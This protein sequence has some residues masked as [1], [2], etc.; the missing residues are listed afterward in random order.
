[1]AL[2]KQFG[3]SKLTYQFKKRGNIFKLLLDAN[4]ASCYCLAYISPSSIIKQ[5][6]SGA[7][8]CKFMQRIAIRA[9]TSVF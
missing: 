6:I 1:M 3:F 5:S 7:A 2:K 8:L 9:L 4:A